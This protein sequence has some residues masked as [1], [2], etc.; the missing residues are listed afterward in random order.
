MVGRHEDPAA[1][2][3][4]DTAARRRIKGRYPW[5]PT[6]VSTNRDDSGLA[7][8]EPVGHLAQAAAMHPRT[9]QRRFKDATGLTAT[10]YVQAARTAKARGLLEL[11]NEPVAH[12]SRSVGYA[13]VSNLRRL[14][15]R[16]TGVTP[17]EY[18]SRFGIA[19]RASRQQDLPT[20]QRSSPASTS[21]SPTTPRRRPSSAARS[22]RRRHCR[23]SPTS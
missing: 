19:A 17:S 21:W 4:G 20:G 23:S 8:G 12:V 1:E 3:G 9:F 11:T 18:R 6:V 22:T 15:Q 14:F 13:D 2:A 7:T 5:R 10:E 16:A